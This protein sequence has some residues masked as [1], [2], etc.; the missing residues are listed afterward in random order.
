MIKI[1]RRLESIPNVNVF[2]DLFI[3]FYA[4]FWIGFGVW[5]SLL[6]YFIISGIMLFVSFAMEVQN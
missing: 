2:F 1:F 6:G 5:H 3:S 4:G